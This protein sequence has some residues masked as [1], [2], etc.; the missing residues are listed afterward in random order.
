MTFIDSHAHFDLCLEEHAID[1]ASLVRGLRENGTG[2]AV[3]VTIDAG[4]CE[5]SLDFAR[6]NASAGLLFTLGIHPSSR[7]GDAELAVL[8]GFVTKVMESGDAPLLFGIGETG[9]DFYRMRQ[10]R[11]AQ[12]RSFERQVEIAR[13]WGLPLIVHSRD[14]TAESIAVLEKYA[15]LKGIMHCFSDGKDA[16][17][18]YL[19]MGFHLSFAGNV[20]YK[21]AVLLQESAAYAPPDR[22]LLE[23]DAPFLTPVPLRGM[24]NR[25][26]Y[27]EHTYRYVADLRGEKLPEFADRIEE[28]FLFLA[29]SGD[30]N[31]LEERQQP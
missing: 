21:T 12:Y 26:E 29:G 16:A 19:D 8:A 11:E 1:E 20:T 28:N 31:R 9:L 22:L 7:G 15:P 18:T 10:P 30:R 13:T 3:Q 4:G 24:K 17:R 23:T 25:P 2:R 5:W 6:R 27:V 14:A